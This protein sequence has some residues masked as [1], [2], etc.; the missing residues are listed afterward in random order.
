MIEV[1]NIS[2]G[3]DGLQV[4]SEVSFRVETGKI[5]FL[6]GANGAGK[7]TILKAL[8]GT[9]KPYSGEILLEGEPLHQLSRRQIAK[10]IAVVSQESE[11]R[12]PVTVLEFVLAGRFA[13]TAFFAWDT[14][15]DL[16]IALA[17]LKLCDLDGY[18]NRL[19]NQLSGGE[20][21]RAVLARALATQA[22]ILLLDEPTNNLD[23]SHQISIFKLVRQR[24][25]NCLSS[26]VVV[27]HDVNLASEFADEII[28]LKNG[29]ISAQGKPSVVLTEK[30]LRL[31]F[32][33]NVLLDTNPVTKHPRVTLMYDTG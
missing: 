22:R 17:C 10:K 1:R 6:L 18:S 19:M 20:R 3:Y 11:T 28:L 31:T 21:Q 30:N 5:V 14:D 15:E 8:N 25:K 13:N 9:L 16:Q 23:L 26:A 24:C 32:D 7:T 12:F 33:V 4:V 2:V 27:T 29:K